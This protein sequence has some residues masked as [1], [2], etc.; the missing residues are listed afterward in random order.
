MAAT[1]INFKHK[2]FDPTKK[3]IRINEVREMV[4]RSTSWIYAEMKKGNFP[5]SVKIS[6]CLCVWRTEDVENYLIETAK[7]IGSG[8]VEGATK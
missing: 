7:R 2:P 8:V 4:W 5:A 1:A 3:H 6:P